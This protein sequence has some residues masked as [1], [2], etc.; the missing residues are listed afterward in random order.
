MIVVPGPAS[1]S[2]GNKIAQSLN[3]RTVSVNLKAFPDGEYC[4]RFEGD[5]AGE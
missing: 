1:Q 3:T 4:L 2:L 5:V